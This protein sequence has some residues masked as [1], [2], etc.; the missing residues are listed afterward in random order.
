MD[1]DLAVETSARG[2]SLIRAFADAGFELRG[3]HEHSV[4]FR[5][6]S[7]EPVQLAFDAWF[8]PIIIRAETFEVEGA[9]IRVV[10]REDLIAMKRRAASATDRRRSKTLRDQADV[11]L[12]L[13]DVPDVDEGW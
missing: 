11:E 9:T 10:T 13:G 7:G 5:H 8:D 12:L 2:G 6:P 1:T 4:N 3:D